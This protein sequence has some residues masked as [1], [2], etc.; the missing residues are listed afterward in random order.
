[1][2]EKKE[3]C[4][5]RMKNQYLKVAEDFGYS[6]KVKQA[7]RDAKSEVEIANIMADARANELK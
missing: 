1:M 5:K 4:G 3:T 6:E 7:I 2:E